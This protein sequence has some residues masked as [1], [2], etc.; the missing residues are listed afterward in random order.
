MNQHIDERRRRK[1]LGRLGLPTFFPLWAAAVS[2]LPS[3]KPL[4]QLS[5]ALKA[6][7]CLQKLCETEYLHGVTLYYS[8]RSSAVDAVSLP[9]VAEHRKY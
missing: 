5:R 9:V 8:L 4:T 1:L 2:S 7:M 6:V 3:F